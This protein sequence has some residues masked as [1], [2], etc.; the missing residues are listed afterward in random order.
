MNLDTDERILSSWIMS[1]NFALPEVIFRISLK[2]QAGDDIM[3]GEEEILELLNTAYPGMVIH[4]KEVDACEVCGG[5]QGGTPG[6]ENIVDA[7][8]MCDYCHAKRQK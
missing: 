2:D 5:M 3:I 4:V 6:N 8:V 7:K 1:N